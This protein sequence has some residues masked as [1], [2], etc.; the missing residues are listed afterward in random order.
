[1]AIFDQ[2]NEDLVS[3]QKEKNEVAVST[4]RMV[5]ANIKNA[6]IAKGE[7]LSD[8]DVLSE[9]AKDAKRHKESITAFG[10]ASRQDLVDKEQAELDVLSKY[11]PE[12][13]GEDEIKAAVEAAISEVN[14]TGMSDMGKV[15]S[16]VMAKVGKSADGGL[17]SGI[18]KEKLSSL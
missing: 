16:A 18:V 8:D 3:A 6:R 17:V 2:L 9:L 12:Q 11:L 15:M 7:D 4:L 1:M 14:P 10:Q 13:M 5:I